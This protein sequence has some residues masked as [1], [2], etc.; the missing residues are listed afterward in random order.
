M[1]KSFNRFFS[2]FV[3]IS[4]AKVYKKNEMSTKCRKKITINAFFILNGK[5]FRE[6]D[7]LDVY[8]KVKKYF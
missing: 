2:Y 6:K 4:R 3:D 7:V 8:N 1:N 5:F